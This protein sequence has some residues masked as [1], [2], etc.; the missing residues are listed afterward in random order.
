MSELRDTEENTEEDESE[1]EWL[2]APPAVRRKLNR[3]A[4]GSDTTSSTHPAEPTPDK[5]RIEEAT[6]HHFMHF[7]EEIRSLQGERI[8]HWMDVTLRMAMDSY[9]KLCKVSHPAVQD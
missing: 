6:L 9:E 8:D 7:I 1:V 4:P 3:T 5:S 2:E